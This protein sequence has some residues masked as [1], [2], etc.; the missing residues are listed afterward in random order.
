MKNFQTKPNFRSNLNFK[1]VKTNVK[2]RWKAERK[3][4]LP[5]RPARRTPETFSQERFRSTRR[6]NPLLT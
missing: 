5:S 3:T 2:G 4:H 1:T 6:H